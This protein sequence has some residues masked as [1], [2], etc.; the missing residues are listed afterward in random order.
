MVRLSLTK[1]KFSCTPPITDS[2]IIIQKNRQG[3]PTI[4][5]T[6]SASPTHF[7]LTDPLHEE[8]EETDTSKLGINLRNR[9]DLF[10]I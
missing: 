5:Q 10:L 1:P 3:F 9:Q 2:K 7:L 6:T 4:T 8:N